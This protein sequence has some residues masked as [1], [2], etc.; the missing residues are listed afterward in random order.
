[1]KIDQIA[2]AKIGEHL[3]AIWST[4]R[5]KG[6]E[7]DFAAIRRSLDAARSSTCRTVAE[8]VRAGAFGNAC[9][10]VERVCLLERERAAALAEEPYRS[11]LNAPDESIATSRK[12]VRP[13]FYC[14]TRL[15]GDG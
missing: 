1:M 7:P 4:R 6:D 12:S 11:V 13:I 15:Q 10:G 3:M 9:R 2:G 8:D 5:E 14:L